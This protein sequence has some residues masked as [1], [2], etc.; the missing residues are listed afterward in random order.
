MIYVETVLYIPTPNPRPAAWDNPGYQSVMVE[1]EYDEDTGDE[2]STAVDA[3]RA[4]LTAWAREGAPP[5]NGN[6]GVSPHFEI[7]RVHDEWGDFALPIV[8]CV[9]CGDT[10]IEY[11]ESEN[12]CAYCHHIT[13]KE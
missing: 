13:T 10:Q 11:R 7:I 1:I 2:Y 6:R 5:R 9:R 3:V 8:P 12:I 4:S